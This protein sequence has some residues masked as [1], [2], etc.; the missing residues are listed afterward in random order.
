MVFYHA[1]NSKW[2]F[3]TDI[4]KA[5]YQLRHDTIV[6]NDYI[7][8]RFTQQS[9]LTS[10]DYKELMANGDESG[11]Y[12]PW[13]LFLNMI[14][15]A[16]QD[17]GSNSWRYFMD[18]FDFS[19]RKNTNPFCD[20]QKFFTEFDLE[21]EYES[22]M[23]DFEKLFQLYETAITKQGNYG[24]M[25]AISIPKAI[26]PEL[27]YS[28][29]VGGYKNP[30]T[31]NKKKTSNPVVIAQHFDQVPREHQFAL[32]LTNKVLNYDQMQNA[33]IQ[34]KALDPAIYKNTPEAQEYKQELM[35][36]MEHVKQLYNMRKQ[37]HQ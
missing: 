9:P 14:P 25:L 7:P 15:F 36:I 3:L 10:E 21:E 34:V 33:G 1:R 32:I 22:C 17:P 13:I 31:I 5:L 2:R 26:V 16:N 20:L 28:A 27:V 29:G 37:I 8:L 35:K 4:Y 24:E 12:R 11:C 23:K 18:N 19:T 6:P 30:L